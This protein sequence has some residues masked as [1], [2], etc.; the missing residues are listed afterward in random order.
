MCLNMRKSCVYHSSNNIIQSAF[1]LLYLYSLIYIPSFQ[2]FILLTLSAL[3][4]NVVL[5]FSL[6][7]NDG[8]VFNH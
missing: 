7:T 5:Y 8:N 1:F 2:Y 4:Q 6:L 3:P